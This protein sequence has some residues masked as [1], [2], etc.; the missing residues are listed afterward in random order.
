MGRDETHDAACKWAF[1]KTFRRRPTPDELRDYKLALDERDR[2]GLNDALPIFSRLRSEAEAV[3]PKRRRKAPQRAERA[4][5]PVSSEPSS[6]AVKMEVSVPIPEPKLTDP[7]APSRK[8][9]DRPPTVQLARALL[10]EQLADGPKPGALVEAAAQAAEIPK[11]EL[12]TA[13]D[14]LDVR[15]RRGQWWLPG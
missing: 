10:Q 3:R 14:G 11:R 9:R 1:R 8:R 2:L 15:A 13:C 5:G 7:E 12:L 4:L 6:Q